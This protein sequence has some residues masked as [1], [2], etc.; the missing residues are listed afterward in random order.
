MNGSGL[1]EV[2]LESGL[3]SS[4]SMDGVMTGKNDARLY[5]VTRLW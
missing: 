4:G 3:M 5:T 1:A 2:L